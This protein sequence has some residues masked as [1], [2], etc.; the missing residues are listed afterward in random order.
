MI[1]ADDTFDGRE[2]A[3]HIGE[4]LEVRLAENASTGYQWSIPPELKHKL[5]PALRELQETIE[6]P[7]GPPGKPGFRHLYFEAVAAGNAEL[8]IHYRRSWETK[9]PP[10]RTFRLHISVRPA[11]G[12]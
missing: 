10:A 8:E 3:L 12:R 5:A 6:A 1:Q 2:L 7:A 11:P 9:K 4:T